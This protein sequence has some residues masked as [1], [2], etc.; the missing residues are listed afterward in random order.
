[1]VSLIGLVIYDIRPN[2]DYFKR[3]QISA[4]SIADIINVKPSFN[5]SHS[6]LCGKFE[7]LLKVTRSDQDEVTAIIF[8]SSLCFR[9]P[10]GKH[11][12]RRARKGFQVELKP[13][14]L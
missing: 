1:M 7:S 8:T 4:E 3:F 13:R 10:F 6:G 5:F 12:C 9:E 11:L 14:L 2:H